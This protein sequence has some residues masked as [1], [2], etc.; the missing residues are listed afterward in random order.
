MDIS[1]NE[2]SKKRLSR[3]SQSYKSSILEIRQDTYLGMMGVYIE[4][5]TGALYV[6]LYV[7]KPHLTA[8]NNETET[9]NSIMIGMFI[10]SNDEKKQ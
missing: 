6:M 1:I 2:E 7:K 8:C 9:K 10:S 5:G 3:G 4:R